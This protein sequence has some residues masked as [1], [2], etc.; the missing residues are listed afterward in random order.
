LVLKPYAQAAVPGRGDTR[1]HSLVRKLLL[2]SGLS[3][4]KI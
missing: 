2:T 1:E 3:R 4:I